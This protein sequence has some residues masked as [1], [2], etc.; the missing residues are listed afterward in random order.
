MEVSYLGS[1]SRHLGEKRN[2]N[3]IPDGARLIDC[4]IP[5]LCHP[6]NKDPVTGNRFGD[7]FLRPY[8]GFGDVNTVMYSGSANY[9]SL[10]LQ[11]NRRYTSN[12][13]YGIAYMWSKA[14]D[15][16]NDD[17]SDV[18][19]SRPYNQFN[20]G[21]ADFDQ[22]HIFTANYIWSLPSP[23]WL[24]NHGL[25]KAAFNNWQLSGTTS[26]VSGKPKTNLGITNVTYSGGSTDYT[27]A[28]RCSHGPSLFVI[29]TIGLDAPTGPAR[30]CGSTHPVSPGRQLWVRLATCSEIL[31]AFRGYSIPTSHFLRMCN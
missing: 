3:G 18:F 21:P 14:L 25:L 9:N 27:G 5:N 17:S 1:L 22:A 8:R 15:Y 16:A 7:D 20:Y 23:R 6:E 13:Q 28:A 10:Q 30:R 24:L 29:R 11:I 19:Y 31:F 4:S 12:F 2:L 26:L